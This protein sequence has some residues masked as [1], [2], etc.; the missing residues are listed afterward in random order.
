[1][2]SEKKVY[3]GIPTDVISAIVTMRAKKENALALEDYLEV[4]AVDVKGDL[5]ILLCTQKKR[6]IQ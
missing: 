2:G 4:E 1:M 6:N 5:S 3:V